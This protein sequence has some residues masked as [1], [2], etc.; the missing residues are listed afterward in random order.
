MIWLLNSICDTSFSTDAIQYLL[1]FSAFITLSR[2]KKGKAASENDLHYAGFYCSLALWTNL[3]STW[4]VCKGKS[5]F[6]ISWR[7]HPDMI[8]EATNKTPNQTKK[9]PTKQKPNPNKT[10]QTNQT[11]QAKKNPQKTWQQNEPK[12]FRAI[13]VSAVPIHK[14]VLKQTGSKKHSQSVST[15]EY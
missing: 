15:W 4:K 5:K 13:A 8:S 9:T 10:K 2:K 1:F 6:L 14:L 7:K 11:H 12:T 3:W